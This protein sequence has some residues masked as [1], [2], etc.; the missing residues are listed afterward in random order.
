[1]ASQTIYL[2]E[3]PPAGSGAFTLRVSTGGNSSQSQLTPIE[4]EQLITLLAQLPGRSMASKA[5]SFDG[6]IYELMIMRVEE[7]LLF[8][9]QNDDW[10]Y[11]PQDSRNKWERVVALSAYA[12]SLAK[13]GGPPR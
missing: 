5:M 8:H 6:I 1:L 10:R 9:W 7:P 3:L 2:S 4:A 12:L 11:C 13:K